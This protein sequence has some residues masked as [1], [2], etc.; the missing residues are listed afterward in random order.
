MLIAGI[1]LEFIESGSRQETR[2]KR[3]RK[4]NFHCPL[5][6][7]IGPGGGAG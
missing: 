3:T 2:N 4:T 7:G 1:K 6:I 5:Q